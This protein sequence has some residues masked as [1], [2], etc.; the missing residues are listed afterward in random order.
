MTRD[1]I[2]RPLSVWPPRPPPYV[3]GSHA[4]ERTW[5]GDRVRVGLVIWYYVRSRARVRDI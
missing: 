4:V 3:V 5:I 1:S 2:E